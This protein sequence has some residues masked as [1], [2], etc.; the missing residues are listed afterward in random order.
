MIRFTNVTPVEYRREYAYGGGRGQR[1]YTQRSKRRG[2][3]GGALALG[4][5]G[6]GA[7]A[8]LGGPHYYRDDYYDQGYRPYYGPRY[9]YDGGYRYRYDYDY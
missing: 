1:Y 2:N 3:Y 5:L 7:A 4:I 9:G 6:L 8:V